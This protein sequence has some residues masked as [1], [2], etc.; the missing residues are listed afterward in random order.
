M[1]LYRFV[2]LYVFT[3]TAWKSKSEVSSW[4]VVVTNV[5]HLRSAF[6]DFWSFNNESVIDSRFYCVEENWCVAD[7]VNAEQDSKAF[8]VSIGTGVNRYA[9]LYKPKSYFI[10]LCLNWKFGPRFRWIPSRHLWEGSFEPGYSK[11]YSARCSRLSF[12]L[13][14]LMKICVNAFLEPLTNKRMIA[15]PSTFCS[16]PSGFRSPPRWF[17]DSATTALSSFTSAGKSDS[18]RLRSFLTLEIFVGIFGIP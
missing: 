10:P 7:K 13:F 17:L 1:L 12:R 18:V 3:Y 15:G 8:L 11:H 4:L 6:S 5:T 14:H 16:V 9:F 2:W